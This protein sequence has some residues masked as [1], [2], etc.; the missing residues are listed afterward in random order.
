MPGT[1]LVFDSSR[2][3][4]DGDDRAKLERVQKFYSSIRGRGGVSSLHGGIGAPRWPRTWLG[5]PGSRIGLSETR[6]SGG[7]LGADASRIATE[8]EKL[9]LYVGAARKVTAD[10]IARL[11]PN[12]QA[13]DHLRSGGRA[14]TRRSQTL[15]RS[16]STLCCARANI[17]RWR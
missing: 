14:R 2:Y 11:V 4:F 9:R 15:A 5:K 13:V 7:C 10:D 3:D 16:V 6:A 12:A 17:C 8:I 1:D